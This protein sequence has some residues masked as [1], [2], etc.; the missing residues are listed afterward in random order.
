MAD[1]GL[2]STPELRAPPHPFYSARVMRQGRA[3]H[4]DGQVTALRFF[5]KACSLSPSSQSLA[6]RRRHRVAHASEA[7]TAPRRR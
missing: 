2:S 3:A 1:A 4:L 7:A 5:A 6:A